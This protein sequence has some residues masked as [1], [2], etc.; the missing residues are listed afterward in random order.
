VKNEP[1]NENYE[2][3]PLKIFKNEIKNERKMEQH[4]F[5]HPGSLELRISLQTPL[6]LIIFPM[7]SISLKLSLSLD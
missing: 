6:Y 3:D 4:V 1:K 7:L 5:R 2:P